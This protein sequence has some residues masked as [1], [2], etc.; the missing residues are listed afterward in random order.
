VVGDGFEPSKAKPA[1]L[2]SAP[3]GHLGNLPTVPN[4]GVQIKPKRPASLK[5]KVQGGGLPKKKEAG[6][7]SG[8]NE[9]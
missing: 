4:A 8:L 7:Y 1:D 5:P 2:Q 9:N 3:V 6:Y